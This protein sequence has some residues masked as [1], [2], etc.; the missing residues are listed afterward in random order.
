MTRGISDPHDYYYRRLF[1]DAVR[2][3]DA[4]R[5]LDGI[6]PARVAVVGQSQGGGIALAAAALVPDLSAVVAHVP[7]LC[8]FP[9]AVVSTDA[10]PFREIADY[11]AVHRD[12]EEV[13]LRTLSYID[14]VNFARRAG[15]PAR[16]SAALMD[17]VVPPP[18]CSAPTTPTP[19]RRRSPSGAT[20]ATRPGRRTTTRARWTFLPA[21]SGLVNERAVVRVLP[22][23]E[24]RHAV[25]AQG[26]E[27][28]GVGVEDAD[29]PGGGES[30]GGQHRVDCVLVAVQ[31][32]VGEERRPSLSR[33]IAGPNSAAPRRRRQA[34]ALRQL[35]THARTFV[36]TRPGSLGGEAGGSAPGRLRLGSCRADGVDRG[37]AVRRVGTRRAARAAARQKTASRV[38]PS[39]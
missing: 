2:A 32:G 19:G 11:L 23:L 37:R 34:E 14:G 10:Y 33:T 39:V 35:P 25:P 22:D 38:K 15:I 24:D 16:F 36:G 30:G 17:A 8:D 28:F 9:R 26:G 20:T 31:C 21:T 5:G 18:R 29:R 13:V 7:F 1:T 27:A 4:V 6:E 12:Q 3:V